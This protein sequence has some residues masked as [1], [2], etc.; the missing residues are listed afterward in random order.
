MTWLIATGLVLGGVLIGAAIMLA[1]LSWVF[2]EAV[3]R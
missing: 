1:V 3:K 2:R